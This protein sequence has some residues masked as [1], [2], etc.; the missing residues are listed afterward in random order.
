[1]D[2]DHDHHPTVGELFR[3][4]H[5]HQCSKAI[6]SRCGLIK[7]EK[8]GVGDECHSTG[9]VDEEEKERKDTLEKGRAVLYGLALG[10]SLLCF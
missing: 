4:L 8:F 1:M 5:Y 7:E 3:G 10:P 6:E 2:G 9:I